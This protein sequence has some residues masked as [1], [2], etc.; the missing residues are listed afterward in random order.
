MLYLIIHS[1]LHLYN[2]SANFLS[3]YLAHLSSAFFFF[4]RYLTVLLHCEWC[5]SSLFLS[6]F[7]FVAKDCCVSILDLATLMNS[8]FNSLICLYICF[9]FLCKLLDHLQIEL[10]VFLF[11]LYISFLFLIIFARTSSTAEVEMRVGISV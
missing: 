7:I 3:E 10:R 2:S 11:N 6:L 9:S 8:L 5:L 1:D 4:S